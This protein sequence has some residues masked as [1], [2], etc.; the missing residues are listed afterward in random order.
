MLTGSIVWTKSKENSRIGAR[1]E[2]VFIV[3]L[4]DEDV[5]ELK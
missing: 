1:Q 5:N 2:V 4:V 3:M